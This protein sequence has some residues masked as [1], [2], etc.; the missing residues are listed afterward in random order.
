[1][2]HP[3]IHIVSVQSNAGYGKSF[4][5]LAAA[6]ALVLEKKIYDKIYAVKPMIEIGQKMGY[7][8]GGVDE[9]MEPYTRYI[10]DLVRKLHRMLPANRIFLDPEGIPP[11]YNPKRF[12]LLPLTYVRGMN[13]ENAVVIVDEI[14]NMSRT[15]CRSLLSRMGEGVKCI[16]LGDVHQV[17]NPYLSTEKQR[18]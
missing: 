10:S 5:A 17:D 1:M 9:K 12:E 6:L 4:L 15:E 2:M 3:D 14:Q 18:S 13:I 8:P 16:C 11:R 7:L